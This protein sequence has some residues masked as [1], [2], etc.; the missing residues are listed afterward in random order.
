MQNSKKIAYLALL[1]ALAIVLSLLENMV[2]AGMEFAIPGV[3]LGLANLAVL[4]CIAWLGNGYALILAI[5]KGGATFLMSASVT[6]LVFSLAGSIA[7][8]LLMMLA[9][10]FYGKISFI[11]IS[12]IGGTAHNCVQMGVMMLI[13]GTTAWF[14]YFPILMIAGIA[15]GA[16]TGISANAMVRGM[17]HISLTSPTGKKKKAKELEKGGKC[18]GDIG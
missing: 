14:Y 12:M 11:G 15:S 5:I 8:A 4:L 1:A 3:K 2:T 13:S 18:S 7:S 9:Y 16:V 10:R 6:V 17:K